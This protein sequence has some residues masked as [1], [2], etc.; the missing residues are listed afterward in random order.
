MWRLYLEYE[1]LLGLDDPLD[2]EELLIKKE[3]Y[4]VKD[5]I[6]AAIESR[7]LLHT[8]KQ[9]LVIKKQRKLPQNPQLNLNINV[10]LPPNIDVNTLP[11]NVQQAIQQ[12]MQELSKTIPAMVNQELVR[13]SPVS[14]LEVKGYGGKWKKE[15]MN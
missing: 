9:N 10:P 3:D 4:E 7:S 12:V 14:G 8:F 15:K 5:L 11:Q 1:K 6:L 2:F 13:Q